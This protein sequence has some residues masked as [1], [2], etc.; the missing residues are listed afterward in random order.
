LFFGKI[1]FMRLVI[2]RVNNASVT[3]IETNDLVGK[4]NKGL[5]ILIG[6]KT[7]DSLEKAQKMAQKVSKMRLMSD[8][9]N[10]MNLSILDT[11]KEILVV[12]QFT[13]YANTKGGNRPSFID[14]AMPH[15]AKKIYEEFIYNLA[16]LG[17]KVEK[18]SFGDYMNI[19][20]SLD[21]PVTIIEEI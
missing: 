3:K 14:A 4:I 8:E 7:G 18:G 10:K 12:S 11:T 17:L 6:I 5:F 21:G 16:N 20:V 15:D 2:Q 13:L 19:N 1:Q 9:Q